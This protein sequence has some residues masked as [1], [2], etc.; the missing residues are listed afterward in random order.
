MDQYA[1]YVW[2]CYGIAFLLL[3]GL[4]GYSLRNYLK[5]KQKLKDLSQ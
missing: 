5:T 4:Y 2:A 1:I 3:T